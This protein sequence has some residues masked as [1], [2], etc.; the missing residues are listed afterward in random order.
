[1]GRKNFKKQIG[2]IKKIT[3]KIYQMEETKKSII[4]KKFVCKKKLDLVRCRRGPDLARRSS[5]CALSLNIQ[6]QVP[7]I[8]NSPRVT[9]PPERRTVGGTGDA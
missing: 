4:Q 5:M 2:A 9:P 1:V 8:T 6:G 3:R 7:S